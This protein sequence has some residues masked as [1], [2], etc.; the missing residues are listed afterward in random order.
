MFESLTG[1]MDMTFWQKMYYITM[2]GGV[3]TFIWLAMS[4]KEYLKDWK[5]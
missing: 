3:G 4:E 1:F 5:T 2:L